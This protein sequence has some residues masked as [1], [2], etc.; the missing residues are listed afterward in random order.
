MNRDRRP[1]RGMAH[2]PDEGG[3]PVSAFEVCP[4]SGQRGFRSADHARRSA[5]RAGNRLRA[6]RCPDCGRYHVTKA[7]E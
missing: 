6:Y 4:T 3:T 1:N 2:D 5:R 7:A